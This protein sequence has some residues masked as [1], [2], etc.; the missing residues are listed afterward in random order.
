MIDSKDNQSRYLQPERRGIDKRQLTLQH[1]CLQLAAL[2]HDCHLTKDRSF[3]SVSYSLLRNYN[4][5]RRLLVDYRCPADQRIQNFLNDYFQRNEVDTQISLPGETFNLHEAGLAREMSLPVENNKHKSSLLESYRVMQGVLHNPAS[6]RRTTQGVFHIVEGGLPIPF[7]KRA[8]PVSV[9][10]K[11]LET[12]L[13]PPPELMELPIT[14]GLDNKVNMWISL[15]LRPVVRP[16]VANVLPEKSLEVR[17]FAPGSLVANLD[18]VETIFGNAGDAF[19]PENDAALDIQ[20]WTGHSGCI[21]L[22]PHLTKLRKKNLG[23]PHYNDASE[24]Q[25]GCRIT[26]IFN[27]FSINPQ[28]R[29]HK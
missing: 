16:K 18:F 29:I 28:Y 27:T 12:A 10:A 4:Q 1:I 23:L 6:D 26:P 25:R 8:V 24:R 21:I 11:L 3:L 9:Y 5:H 17:M 20:H 15:L 19:L 2:G 14:S 13:Q 7:D 22:A